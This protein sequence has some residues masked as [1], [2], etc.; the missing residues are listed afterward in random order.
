MN[1]ELIHYLNS[2]VKVKHN[3]YISDLDVFNFNQIVNEHSTDQIYLYPLSCLTEPIPIDGK[4]KIPL[5][6]L[7]KIE[8]TYKGEE[9]EV[10]DYSPQGYLLEWKESNFRTHNF[11]VYSDSSFSINERGSLRVKFVNNQLPLFQYLF[12]IKI[13]LFPDKIKSI[14]P[15]E[16]GDVN[17]YKI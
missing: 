7:A 4:M 15:R 2:G 6:E 5:V 12:S 8:G 9:Y 16:L 1:N 3:C 13:N 11:I 17:P 14:D 10:M